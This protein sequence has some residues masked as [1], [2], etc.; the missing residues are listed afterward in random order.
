[1]QGII[2]K[3]VGM[4][5]IFSAEGRNIPCTVIEAGPCIVTQ[6]RTMETDGYEAVQLAFDE[7]KDKHTSKAM[8]GHFQKAGTTPK[9]KL[10]EFRDFGKINVDGELKEVQLGDTIDVGIF[11]EGEY[12]D[13]SGRSKGKG[14]QGVMRR[15]GYAGGLRTHGQTNRD[16]APGSIG[17]SSTP[18]RVFKG[19]RMAGQMGDKKVKMIS[20]R[21]IK[22]IPESNL[23]LVKGSVPGAVGSYLIIER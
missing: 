8:Q 3:K 15:Y 11:V 17:S 13:V 18:A 21:V 2:G 23:L 7:K 10:V 1:M 6:I 14:F 5:S 22:V 9:R 12:C 16:R 4:T 20:L 19:K